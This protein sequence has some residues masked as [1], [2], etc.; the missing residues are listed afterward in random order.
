MSSNHPS[1]AKKANRKPTLQPE[2]HWK[3]MEPELDRHSTEAVAKQLL[4]PI[5]SEEEEAEYQG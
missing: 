2:A 5:V 1:A 4:D 3:A